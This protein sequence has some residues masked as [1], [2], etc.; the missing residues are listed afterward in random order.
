MDVDRFLFLYSNEFKPLNDSQSAGLKFLLE[1]LEADANMLDPRWIAYCLAT[2]LHECAGRWQ[3]I[4]EFGKGSGRKYGI[5]DK[6]TGQTYYGRGYV[7]LTWK[8]NYQ[9]MAKVTGFDLV[10]HPDFAMQP[11]VAYRIMSYGMRN[12]SFT[13]VK[14]SMYINNDGCDYLHARKIINGMDKAELIAGYAEK[15]EAILKGADY[16]RNSNV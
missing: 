15:F 14:L 3:P 16:E 1:Q 4:A 5:P 2:T 11:E 7:Q 10:N 13:G 6:V 8:E 9:A 12:G